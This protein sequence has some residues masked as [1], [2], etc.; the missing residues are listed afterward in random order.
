MWLMKRG[1][2]LS[3]GVTALVLAIVVIQTL[4]P[5]PKSNLLLISIDTLRADHLGAY[6]YERRT[7][8]FIDSLAR[9]GL[10]FENALVPL[11]A[12]NPSH[13][14]LLTSLHPLEHTILKNAL[15]LQARPV[16]TMAEVLQQA[17][18]F[19]MGV[20]AVEHLGRAY[21]FDQ[22][23][24]RFSDRWD[25]DDDQN[26]NHRRVATSVNTDALALLNEYAVTHRD[27]PFFLWVH[28]FDPHQPYIGRP[29][30]ALDEPVPAID[31][32]DTDSHNGASGGSSPFNA[33]DLTEMIDR[34]DSE[35]KF[36][37]A[38]VADLIKHIESLDLPRS[39][40]I[41]L[42]SDHGE[43]LGEH[44]FT[45]GHADIYRETVRVPLILH[46]PDLGPGQI[47]RTVSS[48]DIAVTLLQQ[49]GAA[50]SQPVS[51]RSL[52]ESSGA[53][54]GYV[55]T[56][57]AH[58]ER[59]LLVLGYASYTRSLGLVRG[60][61]WFIKNLDNVYRA[62]FIEPLT[63]TTVEPRTR[64]GFTSASPTPTERDDVR[65]V[66][67]FAAMAPH[68]MSVDLVTKGRACPVDLTIELSPDLPYFAEPLRI[69]R[70]IRVSYPLSR[71]DRTIVTVQPG[72]CV[73]GVYFRVVE[74]DDFF[75]QRHVPMHLRV[76]GRIRL[77][78]GQGAAEQVTGIYEGLLTARRSHA[79]DE[80]YDV[81]ADPG[82]TTNLIRSADYTRIRASLAAE[83]ERLF[84]TEATKALSSENDD[85]RYSA[86]EIESLKS[87][88]YIR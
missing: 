20:V 88:G 26:T 70:S 19:T 40:T 44:G 5:S 10:V 84:V 73:D 4:V 24:D 66:I 56:A 30:Y 78:N 75:D 49:V 23:F 46:G 48:M 53:A 55:S 12:T 64:D 32:V 52:L 57:S 3:L 87:L 61:L 34:Y 77:D 27:R 36:V 6:G 43:Q 33:D 18:Y 60:P 74:R 72:A 82:M 8:P 35:I 50:F 79:T 54:P 15:P 31:V 63:D 69:T 9:E 81:T 29:A 76:R 86:E 41:G 38:H 51:G 28:Y 22:G 17:G 67:P 58:D 16:E 62:M 37:D 21:N 2:P 7:S 47:D 65:Y 59:P 85:H 80:L 13:A 42:T 83:V 1:V 25:P 71:L 11:P 39:L 14:S 68:M 45:G